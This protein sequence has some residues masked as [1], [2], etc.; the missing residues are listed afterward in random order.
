MAT[1][2]PYPSGQA[3][4]NQYN[5]NITALVANRAAAGKRIVLADMSVVTAADLGLDKVHPNNNGYEK[6][7]SAFYSAFVKAA[8]KGWVV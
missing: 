2:I 7:A 8:Q 6:M 4:V 3:Q 5:K 1:I